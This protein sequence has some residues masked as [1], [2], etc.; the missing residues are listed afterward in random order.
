MNI[1]EKF[2]KLGLSEMTLKAL[3]EKGFE[4][5]TAIQEKCIPLLLDNKKDIVGVAQTGTGKTAAFGLPIIEKVDPRSKK[6]QA[7]ILAPTR[8]LAI[9]VSEEMNSLKGGKRI[10]AAPIYGGQSY[11]IQF[12]MLREGVQIVVATPGRIIDHIKRKKVDLSHIK[13]FI[14][15][16]ADEMLNMGFLDDVEEIMKAMPDE[17]RM[18]LFSA[19][20]PRKILNLAKKYMPDYKLVEV[21]NKVLEKNLTD[22]IYFEV[23]EG[24][25]LESLSRIIDIEPEFYGLVFCRTKVNVDKIANKLVDRGYDAMGI[26]GDIS[27]NMREKIFRKFKSKKINILVA[28]DVAARGI[29]VSDLTHVVNYSLP[30]DP[31]S[32]VHRIGRTGRAGKQGTAI[33][34]ITPYEYSRFSFIKRVSKS[35]VRKE[36]LPNVEQ[37][38]K[39]RQTKIKSDLKSILNDENHKKY[40]DF[41]KELLDG[42]RAEDVVSAILKHSFEKDLDADKYNEIREIS[43]DNKGVSRLFIAKGKKHG[44]TKKRILDL[45]TQKSGVHEKHIDDLLV[46]DGC[47][48]ANVP[49]QEAEIILHAF[50]KDARG[51][52]PVVV[53]AKKREGDRGGRRSDRFRG[54]GRR[55]RRG[56]RQR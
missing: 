43:V 53:K 27:Q 37:I 13:H 29:D 23:Q 36:K 22:Q 46:L 56:G 16:E 42:N 50:K 49:F 55:S 44:V 48:F 2:K 11:N 6:I 3:A 32:Y 39:I 8:E 20:M 9:Q 15:D 18:L 41:A 7:M 47:S 35:E 28:T 12:R 31:E 19:T 24:D 4:E 5:P 26:H 21:K 52:R 14:I 10:K 54:K 25:K 34:F 45:I 33:T 17:K 51:R 40:Q 30:Q 1:P 38:I